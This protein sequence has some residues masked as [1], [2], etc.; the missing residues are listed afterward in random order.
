LVQNLKSI[1]FP[2]NVF[3]DRSCWD[4]SNFNSVRLSKEYMDSALRQQTNILNLYKQRL[5]LI[6]KLCRQSGISPVFM[7]QP[8][9]AGDSMQECI[10]PSV[11]F[12]E[13]M[14]HEN[15]QLFWLKLRM[16]NEVTK[17]VA[18]ISGVPCIDLATK[19]PKDPVYFYDLIHFTNEGA[20]KV[21][22]IVDDGLTNFLAE[23][24]SA[25]LKHREQQNP[26]ESALLATK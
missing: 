26:I 1:F 9:I 7:T 17:R 21:A 3:A 5:E 11:D 2:Q 19:M 13:F 6:V 8:C 22:E 12:H 20:R 15:A 25:Y 10:K 4:F 23:K 24:Y 18:L 16:Y 14:N